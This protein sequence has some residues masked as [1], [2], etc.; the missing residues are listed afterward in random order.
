MSDRELLRSSASGGT[1]ADE[2]NNTCTAFCIGQR[3]PLAIMSYIG[4][5]I[6]AWNLV[7]SAYIV[8]GT[9]MYTTN[10]HNTYWIIF[11]GYSVA[12]FVVYAVW[13]GLKMPAGRAKNSRS[14]GRLYAAYWLFSGIMLMG[15]TVVWGLS[16]GYQHG[17]DGNSISFF[18]D[19]YCN[20]F[21]TVACVMF[22]GISMLSVVSSILTIAAGLLCL[23]AEI[24][25]Y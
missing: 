9:L 4:M 22:T 11:W 16:Q 8:T 12:Q 5:A 3:T 17:M 24:Y 23:L 14:R 13:M 2:R 6:A 21:G 15:M 25:T 18:E 19:G 10:A 7:I 1:T 20:D